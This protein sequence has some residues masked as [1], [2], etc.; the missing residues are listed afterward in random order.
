MEDFELGG[1]GDRMGLSLG[2][3]ISCCGGSSCS[4]GENDGVPSPPPIDCQPSCSLQDMARNDVSEAT[5]EELVHRQTTDRVAPLTA[6]EQL[7]VSKGYK[8][9][10]KIPIDT[11]MPWRELLAP[12][13]VSDRGELKRWTMK[14][15]FHKSTD[16]EDF[17]LFNTGASVKLAEYI[18]TPLGLALDAGRDIIWNRLLESRLSRSGINRCTPRSFPN[19][20]GEI[21]CPNGIHT[22]IFYIGWRF[23]LALV[24]IHPKNAPEVVDQ[25]RFTLG[26]LGYHYFGVDPEVARKL[27]K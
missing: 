6:A 17:S 10:L 22:E 7:A 15:R 21:L 12:Y 16:C 26:I 5:A 1:G 2:I 19:A 18:M 11:N 3:R 20:R 4:I 24:L 27:K 25:Q 14:D 13:T 8:Q 23:Y 9:L